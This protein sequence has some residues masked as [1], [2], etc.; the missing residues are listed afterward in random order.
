M[1]GQRCRKRGEE[2]DVCAGG[3]MKKS[4]ERDG[5]IGLAGLYI[6][7]TE[8]RNLLHLHGKIR[9]FCGSPAPN[10]RLTH[11]RSADENKNDLHL[12]S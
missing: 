12:Q 5:T 3:E 9:L 2:P 1:G 11:L 6:N 10:T 7:S 8:N 4:G